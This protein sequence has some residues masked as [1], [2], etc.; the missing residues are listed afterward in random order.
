[1]LAWSGQGVAV[2][3]RMPHVDQTAW[4]LNSTLGIAVQVDLHCCKRAANR[5]RVLL[6]L[7]DYNDK[8]QR[9]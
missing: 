5:R 4:N 2:Q 6:I 1:M 7:L 8:P 3:H 9:Q